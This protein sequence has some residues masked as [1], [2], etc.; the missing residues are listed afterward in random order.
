[1][2]AQPASNAVLAYGPQGSQQPASAALLSYTPPGGARRVVASFGVPWARSTP[3]SLEV[4][5]PM[6]HTDAL[7][8][9][10][11]SPWGHGTPRDRQSGSQWLRMAPTDRER[12]APWQQFARRLQS[13]SALPWVV[14]RRADAGAR[15]PWG[16]FA[17]RPALNAVAVWVRAL[18]ND[19]QAAAPWGRYASRPA[20]ALRPSWATA[21]RADA[22]RWIPWVR[23]SRTLDAGWGVV[24]PP[25]GPV[26][27]EHGTIVVP[28]R[29]VYFMTNEAT[30]TRVDDGT[31]LPL[32][33]LS[34]STDVDSWAW[35]ADVSLPASSMDAVAPGMDGQP[36][37]LQATINGH[38][39][40]FLAE[41]IGRERVFAKDRI[42]VSGRSQS[43]LLADP[44]AVAYSYYSASAITA[45]QAAI[46]AV[47]ESGLPLGWAI[48]WGI[49][50]WLLPT[51]LWQHQGTPLSAVQRIA[52]AA[53][54]Y[55]QTDMLLKTLLVRHRYPAAPWNWAAL[56]P[57]IVLPLGV[58]LRE[59]V[60]W[61][62]K[63]AYNEVYVTGQAGGVNG[64]GTK[65]GTTGGLLAPEVV[66]DLITHADAARQ[67]G[68]AILSDTGR[69]QR[70]SLSLPINDDTG[71]LAVGQLIDINEGSGAGAT[72]RR[73]LV[74]SVS[75][76][77][78]S[79]V[80]RQNVE[81]Q[82]HG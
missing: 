22:E 16:Q 45:Q 68:R 7:D 5:A 12:S 76:T 27:D 62:D 40:R 31:A 50:D 46:N 67:R 69:Q 15:A 72:T 71:L 74:R 53:G 65:V 63:P 47:T 41:S 55:V 3:R 79:P 42:K 64:H 2:S 81:V 48:D 18:V 57:D 6:H 13:Q 35:R 60:E 38:S 26:V 14:S 17:A 24:T 82:V 36:V 21:R 78:A 51:G 20:L 23:F 11:A 49:D 59:G 39:V 61:S 34:F 77:Y 32:L 10:V 29:T 9:Q 75:A 52:E 44:F 4:V 54:A 58:A 70:I 25:G 33:S 1:M 73:G 8:T 37:L 56:T 66:D 30:L 28:V 19:Q 80:A 43:A